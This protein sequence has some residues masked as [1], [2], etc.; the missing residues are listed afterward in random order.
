[1]SNHKQ[2][3][4]L[5]IFRHGFADE[6]EVRNAWTVFWEQIFE[7]FF[8]IVGALLILS[9]LF[10]LYKM[11]DSI[12]VGIIYGVGVFIVAQKIMVYGNYI[13]EKSLF[14]IVDENMEMPR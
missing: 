3:S 9:A 10:A 6:T 14:D 11:T 2:R 8:K 5:D 7:E 13:Y 1:M 4:L 12:I